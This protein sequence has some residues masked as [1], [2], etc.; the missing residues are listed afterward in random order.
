MDVH[1][2]LA[3]AM[4]QEEVGVC[5]PMGVSTWRLLSLVVECLWSLFSLLHNELS[6]CE[7]FISGTLASFQLRQATSSKLCI[8]PSTSIGSNV[9]Q[10]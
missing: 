3:E 2:V 4:A 6:S 9:R 7:S 1:F 8:I 5:L 10:D